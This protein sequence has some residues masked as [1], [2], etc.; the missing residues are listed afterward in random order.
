[1]STLPPHISP[2]L[3]SPIRQ[4][5]EV[6]QLSSPPHTNVA[7]EA[8]SIGVDVRHGGAAT[9]ITSLDA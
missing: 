5:T 6:P 1:L 3:R 8:A 9:T 7:D 2:T 4:E